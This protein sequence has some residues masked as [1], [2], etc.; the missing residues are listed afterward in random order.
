MTTVPRPKPNWLKRIALSVVVLVFFLGVV[1]PGCHTEIHNKSRLYSY[2]VHQKSILAGMRVF[3]QDWD[4]HF[5]YANFEDDPFTTST[6][7]LQF[8]MQEIGVSSETIFYVKGNPEKSL[9]NGDGIL[10]PAENCMSYV[11][12]Q[13]I[14]MPGGSPLIADEMTGPGT[15]GEHHP[16]LHKRKA[17]VGYIDGHASFENLSSRKPGA[18]IPGPRGSGIDNIFEPAIYDEE[19]N[20]TGGGYLAVPTENILHP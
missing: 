1:I 17:V 20:W 5:P 16:L 14:S 3:A 18:T 8:L 12:N 2:V 4:G 13:T 11:S 9:P 15:F 10:E 7:A 6:E 19:G